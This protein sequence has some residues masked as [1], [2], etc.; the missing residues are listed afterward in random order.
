LNIKLC[1]LLVIILIISVSGCT[2][3]EVKEE[4][5]KNT[6]SAGMAIK[7]T[8]SD[9]VVA[10]EN[11]SFENA[12]KEIS[13][14]EKFDLEKIHT[15]EDYKNFAD[16]VN[17]VIDIMNENDVDIPK[18]KLTTDEY[19]RLS[20]VITEYSPLIDNYNNVVDSARKYDENNR[21]SVDEFSK[22]T[23]LF[24]LEFA[25]ISTAVLAGPVYKGVGIV[26]RATGLNR[27]AFACPSCISFILGQ[28]HWF[29]RGYMVDKSSEIAGNIIDCIEIIKNDFSFD[30]LPQLPK[31][32]IDRCAIN[33]N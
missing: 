2:A 21:N 29:V 33:S 26:Y 22:T 25:I 1:T 16:M 8:I 14:L 11:I 3:K 17:N 20:K 27:I 30:N 19:T 10:T 9:A 5:E 7:E 4:I 15:F 32:L 28:A 6:N 13:K 31:N 24:G 12:A 18:L 23:A